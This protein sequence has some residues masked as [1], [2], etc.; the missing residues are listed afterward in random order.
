M[1]VIPYAE[2]TPTCAAGE[3]PLECEYRWVKPALALIMLGTNDAGVT[4]LGYYEARMR[5]IIEL[6]INRGVIPVVSTIPP[7]PRLGPTGQAEAEVNGIITA[8]AEEYGVPLWDYWAAVQ[9][10]PGYGLAPDLVHPAIVGS[11]ADFSAA[12]LQHGMTVRNL[13]ALQA[14]D[15]VWRAV[16]FGE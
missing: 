4:P 13:T 16:W 12:G 2:R 5:E 6:S 15:A 7:Y 11:P 1:V 9:G 3:T 14:L 10:L 8:L